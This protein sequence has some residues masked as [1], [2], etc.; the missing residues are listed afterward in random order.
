MRVCNKTVGFKLTSLQLS[1]LASI[2]ILRE[3]KYASVHKTHLDPTKC[4]HCPI[5]MGEIIKM[6]VTD[7]G[8]D[9]IKEIDNIHNHNMLIR[10]AVFLSA[11]SP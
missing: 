5:S 7:D 3:L 1:D 10:S 6:R 8:Q 11:N 9:K 2:N 4:A